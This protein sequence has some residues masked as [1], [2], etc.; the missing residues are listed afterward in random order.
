MQRDGGPG[1][2]GG[3]GNPTGGSFTGPA[4]ALEIIGDHAYGVSGLVSAGAVQGTPDT[5]LSFTTGNYYFVGIIQFYYATDSGSDDYVYSVK[6]NGNTVIRYLVAGA[7]TTY[8]HDNQ[9]IIPPYTEVICDATNVSASTA[10]DQA[11]L[12]TGR[13]YRG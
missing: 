5:L 9:I 10:L 8:W 3:A 2:A 4:E 7:T 6:L 13:I 12:M 1:G 11:A